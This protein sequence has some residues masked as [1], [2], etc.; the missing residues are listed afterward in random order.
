VQDVRALLVIS[1]ISYLSNTLIPSMMAELETAFGK[2]YDHEKE[3][4]TS[5][6]SAAHRLIG[7]Y[8]I[9]YAS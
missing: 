5:S 8:R 7:S 1:N 6:S 2:S 3:V 9:F 4:C